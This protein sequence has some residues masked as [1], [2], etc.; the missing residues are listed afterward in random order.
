MAAAIEWWRRTGAEGRGSLVVPQEE[1]WSVGIHVAEIA[2]RA[3]LPPLRCAASA[4][5]LCF[6]A[7]FDPV[8]FAQ[9]NNK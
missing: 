5:L 3:L 1:Q 4:A 2:R 6:A 7:L 9:T 8:C